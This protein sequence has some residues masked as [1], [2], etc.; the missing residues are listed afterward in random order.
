METT[1][2]PLPALPPKPT[3]RSTTMINLITIA[4]LLLLLQVPLYFVGT[5]QA[6][7]RANI[8]SGRSASAESAPQASAAG[9]ANLGKAPADIRVT[10]NVEAAFEP[11]R[12][13]ERAL[14]YNVLVLVLVFAAFFLFEML[15][16]LRLHAVHYGLVG[17]AMALFYLALLAF[18]EVISPGQAYVG[19]AV[20]SSL[21]I[22]LYSLPILHSGS[23]A[24][25]IGALLA[26][27]HG[28]L[29]VVLRMEH[30]ALLAGT[31]TL[32]VVLGAIMYLTR[33]VDWYGKDAGKEVVA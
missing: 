32:F 30:L 4:A 15:C 21:L 31:A 9:D 26:C 8:A 17:A 28:V 29:Y 10:T 18:G 22:T 13:V 27:V 19:A 23:R 25:V 1:P 7:R 5:L 24:T 11:Y 6:E 20:A 14:K 2:P 3:R 12:M 33:H 16:G